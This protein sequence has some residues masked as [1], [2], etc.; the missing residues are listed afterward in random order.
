MITTI[1]NK[2]EASQKRLQKALDKLSL[3]V[4]KV[5]EKNTDTDNS[6][7]QHLNMINTE[8]EQ[9]NASL[10]EQLFSALANMNTIK[11]RN[12]KIYSNLDEVISSLEKVK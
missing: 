9:D 8:L 7:L 12:K 11:E 10:K 5:A 6:K 1:S 3:L 2:L 4:H